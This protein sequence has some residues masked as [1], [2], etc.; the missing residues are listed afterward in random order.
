MPN[1]ENSSNPPN[2]S[3]VQPGGGHY[4]TKTIRPR[5]AMQVWMTPEEFRG[6]LRG[7]ILKY[8]CSL[9]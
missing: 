9:R 6:F 2:A 4:R 1:G 3:T 5:D 8:P 7:N